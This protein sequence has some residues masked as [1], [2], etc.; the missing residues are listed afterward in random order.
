MRRLAIA[1]VLWPLLARAES[2]DQQVLRLINAQRKLAGLA[3]VALD[4]KLSAGCMKHAEYMKLNAGTDAMDGLNAHQERMDLPGASKDGAACGK[5]ADLFPGVSNFSL[6]VDGWMSGFYH[7]R[8]ILDPGLKRIGFGYAPLADGSYMAALMFAEAKPVDAGWPVAYPVANQRD[9]P[10]EYGN[11]IPNPVPAGRGG[12]PIT[13]QFPPFDKVT[14]VSAKLV[15]DK[16][17]AVAFFLSDPQH[18]ATSFGQYGVVSVIAKQPLRAGTTYAIEITATWRDKP[19]TWRWSFATIE[20]RA[21]DAED[22][23]AMTAAVGVPSRARGV[24][25][26]G[27]MM[28]AETAFLALAEG[29]HMVSVL[30][31]IGIWKQLAGNAAPTSWKGVAVEVDATPQLAQDKFINLPIAMPEQLRKVRR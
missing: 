11:E 28:D 8:P 15:D 31:P 18:P 3:E 21:V 2:P 7:R 20:R 12:Y 1:I 25:R 23:A 24:I 5:A 17:H 26:Y 30:I 9:V 19:Q 6:A 16:Q 27:G 14:G 22:D 29:R 13:L 10:L 4:D